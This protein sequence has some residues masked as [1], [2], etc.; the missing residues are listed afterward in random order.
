[1]LPFMLGF[2]VFPQL[3]SIC[4]LPPTL[5]SI[6]EIIVNENSENKKMTKDL[7]K[8]GRSTIFDFEYNLSNKVNKEEFETMILNHF[9]LR[10]IGYETYTSWHIAFENK[11][12]EIVPLYNKLFDSFDGWDIFNDG[13]EITRSTD[14]TNTDST[15][16]DSTVNVGTTS[17]VR[18]SDTPQSQLSDVRDGSY[19]S[20]YTYDQGTSE[21]NGTSSST[22][23]GTSNVEETVKRTP[24]DKMSIYKDYLENVKSIYSMIYK[25]LDCLFYQII[26]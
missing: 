21:T 16:T 11:I 23:N 25:D 12:K 5:Y 13:E 15:S 8:Y 7:A 1:M 3:P 20:D 18:S 10:R 22:S 4:Q 6:L 24:L 17:D 26:D 9:L 2:P 19:V 14:T